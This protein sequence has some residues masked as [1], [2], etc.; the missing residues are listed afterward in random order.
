MSERDN[1]HGHKTHRSDSLQ[2]THTN[3]ALNLSWIMNLSVKEQERK[4]LDLP[5]RQYVGAFPKM[6]KRALRRE[7]VNEDCL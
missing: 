7:F 5:S 1:A 3:A 2:T 4:I 6:E